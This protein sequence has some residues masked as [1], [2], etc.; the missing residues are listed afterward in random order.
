M[1]NNAEFN[2]L[3]VALNICAENEHKP[4]SERF[5]RT[6][7]ERCRMCFSTLKFGRIPR[8]MVV[9]LVSCQI[10]W[11][12][13]MTPEDYVSNTLG[14]ASIVT[15]RTYDYNMLCGE[16]SIYGEY[17]QTNK[18]TD[19]SIK[20]RTVSAITMRL[21]GNTQG[22]FYYYSLAT[23][24]RLR[25]GRCTPLPM[26]QEVIDQV[27]A[28]AEKQN[29]PERFTYTRCDGSVFEEIPYEQATHEDPIA[30]VGDNIDE[31]A[32]EGG[33]KHEEHVEDGDLNN[34][35]DEINEDVDVPKEDAHNDI[36][37]EIPADD[38]TVESLAEDA[39]E[40]GVVHIDVIND[41]HPEDVPTPTPPP[42]S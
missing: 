42:T 31:N 20:E 19:N 37:N 8:R 41:V 21:T 34:D 27:H 10:F 12:N 13:F 23:G 38:N 29:A 33:E 40:V 24:R 14:S 1:R 9:E 25:R 18:K 17:V 16:G 22:S 6:M 32:A 35:L 4:Y 36:E 2:K 3:N 26:P 39:E 28:I 5:N 7:K 15:G 11:Y 30:P